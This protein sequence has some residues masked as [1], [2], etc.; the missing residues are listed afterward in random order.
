MFCLH[1]LT[2]L[3]RIID[4][5]EKKKTRTLKFKLKT[6]RIYFIDCFTQNNKSKS[7]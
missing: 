5:F 4:F 1:I 6:N 7:S 2:R 3:Q